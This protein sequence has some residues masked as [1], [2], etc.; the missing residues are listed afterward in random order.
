MPDCGEKKLTG[1]GPSLCDGETSFVDYFTSAER[2]GRGHRLSRQR[3][4]ALCLSGRY[5]QRGKVAESSGETSNL[6]FETLADWEAHLK[7]LD[8]D[9]EELSHEE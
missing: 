6:L 9:F 4:S 5:K 1:Q 3:R 8:I 2:H 7:Q